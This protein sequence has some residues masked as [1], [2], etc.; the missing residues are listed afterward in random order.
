MP[1][2]E[3][4]GW[5]RGVIYQADDAEALAKFWCDVLGTTVRM[6]EPGWLELDPGRPGGALL[7]FE[8]RTSGSGPANAAPVS[9]DIEIGDLDAAQQRVEALG[10]TLVEV[11]HAHPG[12]THLVMADP[13]G[14]H[15]NLVLPFPPGWPGTTSEG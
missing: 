8:P 2:P 7:A 4:L 12:E 15:F 5:V 11:V 13:E 3:P 14:N 10:A 1:R 9:I 6:H